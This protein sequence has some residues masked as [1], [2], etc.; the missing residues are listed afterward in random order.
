MLD[1]NTLKPSNFSKM[2]YDTTQNVNRIPEL[3][4]DFAVGLWT[5]SPGRRRLGNGVWKWYESTTL[6]V[7]TGSPFEPV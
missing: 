7:S 3:V 5:R 6:T 4:L 2:S 1:A